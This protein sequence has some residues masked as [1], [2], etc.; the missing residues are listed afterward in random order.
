ML[1]SVNTSIDENDDDNDDND[2]DADEEKDIIL[3]PSMISSHP[4]IMAR[5]MTKDMSDNVTKY[6]TIFLSHPDLGRSSSN[7]GMKSTWNEW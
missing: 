3:F 5:V 6:H 1:T 4:R 2:Y 7:I